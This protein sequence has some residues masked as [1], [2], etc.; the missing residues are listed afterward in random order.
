MNRANVLQERRE[1][2]MAELAQ[3]GAMRRGS[4]T[5]QM[6]PVQRADGTRGERGPYPVYTY[7]DRG[8]TRSRRLHTKGEA[9]RYRAQIQVFRRFQALTAQLL[10]IGERLAELALAADDE[11]K[12]RAPSPARTRPGGDAPAGAGRGRRACLK[13]ARQ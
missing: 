2:I 13:F 7:K 9:E 1:Q 8:K 5:A 12:L 6:V 10:E 4:V 3:L 11:K